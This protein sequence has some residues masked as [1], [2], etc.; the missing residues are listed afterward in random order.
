[1]FKGGAFS[2]ILLHCI[3]VWSLA[4]SQLIRQKQHDT[5]FHRVELTLGDWC[6]KQRWFLKP[7]ASAEEKAS[8]SWVG[9]IT[10]YATKL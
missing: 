3:Q 7:P 4:A 1:M 5:D 9:L 2:S 8:I 6:C 10:G